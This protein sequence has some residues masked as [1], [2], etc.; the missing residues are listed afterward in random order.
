M[1]RW[2]ITKEIPAVGLITTIL[3]IAAA[4]FLAYVAVFKMLIPTV[5][6]KLP[7]LPEKERTPYLAKVVLKS[8]LAIA[9][10]AGLIW[11]ILNFRVDFG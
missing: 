8:L 10:I 3:M 6:K 2:Y 5:R 7:A 1:D 11:L 9:V 4:C